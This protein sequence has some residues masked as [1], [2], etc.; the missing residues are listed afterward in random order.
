MPLP[1][2]TDATN[3]CCQRA[4]NPSGSNRPIIIPMDRCHQSS[5]G[6][7][8]PTDSSIA[9]GWCANPSPDADEGIFQAYGLVYRLMQNN[10]TVYW[11]VNPSKDPQGQRGNND[12]DYSARDVDFWVL[13]SGASIPAAGGSLTSCAA[14]TGCNYPIARLDPSDLSVDEPYTKQQFPV[15]GSA[16]LIAAED[17]ARFNDFW[18]RT[19]DFAVFA[20]DSD[21]DFSDV[22]LYEIQDSG[23]IYFQDYTSTAPYTATARAPVAATIDYDPPKLARQSSGNV[24]G[25]WLEKAKLDEEATTC[26]STTWSP[27]TAVYCDVSEDDISNGV[28]VSR[29]FD[30]AWIDGISKTTPCGSL[31][32]AFAD[33]MTTD[34]GVRNG[35]SILFQEGVIGVLEED[36]SSPI[37]GGATGALELYGSNVSNEFIQRYPSN[38]LLQFGDFTADLAQGQ[39][40]GWTYDGG[41]YKAALYG[42]GGT[43]VRLM[44]QDS[45]GGS[46][47]VSCE[48]P[49]N[50]SSTSCDIFA[51]DSDADVLDVAAYARHDND[52]QNGIAFYLPGN[53]VTQNGNAAHLRMILNAFIAVPLG[54]ADTIPS[55]TY[56]LTRSSPVL[57]TIGGTTWRVQGS[58]E[59]ETP[60]PATPRIE[61]DTDA[62]T[63]SF[64][65]TIGHLRMIDAASLSDTETVLEDI[66]S[67]V[68]D[69]DNLI[70][71]TNPDGCASEFSGTCR[72]VFTNIASGASP[73]RVSFSTANRSSLKP[74]LGSSLADAA[75]DTL[76]SRVLAGR[77]VNG[78]WVPRLGGI[79]RSSAAV[80]EPSGKAGSATRPTMI[81]VGGLDGM[82]HAIC[83]E[84]V[85]PCPAAGVELWAYIPRTQLG[86]LRYNNQRIDGSPRVA[87]IQVTLQGGTKE[88][89]TVLFFATGY[90]ETASSNTAPSIIALDVTDPADPTIL[91][92]K[93][94]PS[95]AASLDLGT[96]LD[97]VVGDIKL[98]NTSKTVLFAAT[99]NGGS[100]S[101]GF[102]ATAL[103]ADDGTEVWS[104]SRAYTDRRQ[105]GNAL[106]PS[107][108]IMSGPTLIDLTDAGAGTHLLVP[109]LYGD[110][111][112]LKANSTD[113]DDINFFTDEDRPIFSFTDDHHPIG[114]QASVYRDRTSQILHAVIAT[115]GYADPNSASWY[116]EN[117]NQWLLAIALDVA[118]SGSTIT[119]DGSQTS[120][121]NTL[122]TGISLAIPLLD[123]N[124]QKRRAFGSAIIA[125]N[126][127]FVASDGL[128]G[129]AATYGTGSSQS[130]TLQHISIADKA[131]RSTYALTGG[132]AAVDVDA[133]GVVQAG[134]GA[135]ISK[136]TTSSFD[137]DGESVEVTFQS[138]GNTVSR[139][140]WLSI[141]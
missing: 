48:S 75:I 103:E 86:L 119:F 38:L 54:T 100:G 84:A 26:T 128:D 108:G 9:S 65:Y 112:L 4:F 126:D 32:D 69:A 88:W 17:R 138:V 29:S 47:N 21:Y 66:A 67:S 95:S 113:P 106:P 3:D 139:S 85:T 94:T 117:K 10:I 76:I 93:S 132:A 140:V 80:I 83:A 82:M 15:R 91:W 27:S 74:F 18:T 122:P 8:A 89:R 98:G 68:I 120:A 45:S 41:G 96:G 135:K 129:N 40:K 137:A 73:T 25:Q 101:A 22:D 79:D 36:C 121:P 6:W 60:D 90:G 99:S 115:G 116:D 87:D 49:M 52:P 20:G 134:S 5:G 57:A 44:S 23:T 104:F 12:D 61:V 77:L 13:S 127:I 123:A 97:L 1:E 64:P 53:Q 33:F 37:M 110:L 42:S 43:L 30:W 50:A 14:A 81:Y 70:P 55:E 72:T 46:G 16:F 2:C 111:W 11:L 56:E 109:T 105:T 78:T 71:A 51:L 118:A 7:D 114:A 130:G 59:V 63:F 58:F 31:G 107:S 124:G 136:I 141:N 62:P 133:S 24:S 92:E 34:P 102:Y 35:G 125:G 131:V 39:S 19:G 28:L